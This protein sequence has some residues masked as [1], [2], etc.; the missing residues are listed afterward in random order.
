MKKEDQIL[1]YLIQVKEDVSGIKQHLKD[2]NGRLLKHD[3]KIYNNEKNINGV[4]L[5]MAKWGGAI[6][7]IVFLISF[8]AG[9]I[10]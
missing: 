1:N 9:K 6:G 5:K 7:V 8:V 4:N 3:E 2:M 10:L